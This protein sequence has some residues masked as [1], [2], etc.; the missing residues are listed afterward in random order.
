MK[1]FVLTPAAQADIEAI[2]DYSA[3]RWGEDQAVRYVQAI[4]DTCQELVAGTRASRPVDIR[5]GYSR[6]QSGS[7]TLY[8]KISDTGQMVVVRILHQRMDA[9][10]HLS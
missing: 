1:R 5:P 10:R 6:C 3:R 9:D 8:F 7:H 4:R 2:W